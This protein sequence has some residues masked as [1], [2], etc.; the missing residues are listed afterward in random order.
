MGM[1][2]CVV[3]M[4][5]PVYVE[6]PHIHVIHTAK[7]DQR[8]RS[9]E[10]IP[11]PE[12]HAREKAISVVRMDRQRPASARVSVEATVEGT[13]E[14]VMTTKTGFYDRSL[15]MSPRKPWTRRPAQAAEGE[16]PC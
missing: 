1:R 8:C 2:G 11:Q 13:T 3:G 4:T 10:A 16:N 7:H 12:G 14:N 6:L 9:R 15:E 5:F